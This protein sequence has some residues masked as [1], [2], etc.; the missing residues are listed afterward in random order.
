[1]GR[2]RLR[3]FLG[4]SILCSSEASSEEG[5][6]AADVD[7]DGVDAEA[8]SAG[9]AAEDDVAGSGIDQESTA[10]A[11]PSDFSYKVEEILIIY[12]LEFSG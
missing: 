7:D 6:A 8:G 1:L 2:S 11:L 9:R 5:G 12:F 3:L 4:V 10:I